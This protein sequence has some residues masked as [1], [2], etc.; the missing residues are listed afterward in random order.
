MLQ[1]NP[2][3]AQQRQL[4]ETQTAN[5]VN[6]PSNHKR[7]VVT[8]PVVFHVVYNT[9]AQNITDAQIQSQLTSLNAVE[10]NSM[11]SIIV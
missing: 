7:A 9:T 2:S 6:N 4:I 10:I 8:I 3:F 5:Y 1:N 11:A